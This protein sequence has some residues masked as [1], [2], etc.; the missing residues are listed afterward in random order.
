M[1]SAWRGDARNT[2]IPNRPRSKWAAPVAII[3]MAQHAS[4][5]VAGH[6]LLRRAHFTRSSIR[7]VRKLWLRSSRPI[8]G[9]AARLG[10]WGLAAEVTRVIVLRDER[11]EDVAPAGAT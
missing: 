9:Q 10:G 5:N 6:T 7:P 3:S 4:P 1:R 8:G 11:S 2:S